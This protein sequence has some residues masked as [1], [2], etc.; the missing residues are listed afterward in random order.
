MVEQCRVTLDLIQYPLWITIKILIM[1][2]NWCLMITLGILIVIIWITSKS[3]WGC[4]V[5][6]SPG[7][8]SFPLFNIF[9]FI[10][11]CFKISPVSISHFFRFS[12]DLDIRDFFENL[13]K[14][15]REPYIWVEL[16][17]ADERRSLERRLL[18]ILSIILSDYYFTI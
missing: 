11:I 18:S 8:Q 14:S 5:D 4:S 17:V 6:S 10:W 9:N 2:E 15:F 3:N 16:K 13:F 7:A 12:R 1:S